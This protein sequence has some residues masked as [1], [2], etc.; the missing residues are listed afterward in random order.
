MKT[1]K[2]TPGPWVR[3]G[4]ALRAMVRGADMSIV[5][6]RHRLPAAVNEANMNLIGA[7][8]KLLAALQGLVAVLDAPDERDAA[9][10]AARAAIAE[11]LGDE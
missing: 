7:A 3:D 9:E 8:P 11:A 1:F 10:K 5:A 6:V 4:L 2:G